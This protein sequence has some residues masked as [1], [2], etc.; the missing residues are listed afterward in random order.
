MLK[1]SKRR[2][3]QEQRRRRAEQTLDTTGEGEGERR[4]SRAG[5]CARPRATQLA[6][7][8]LLR[9]AGAAPR[10]AAPGGLGG[11]GEAQEGADTCIILADS[12]C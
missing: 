7:G 6:D 11:G 9:H 1:K 8:E 4:E 5:T 10:S 3:R 2:S 12:R